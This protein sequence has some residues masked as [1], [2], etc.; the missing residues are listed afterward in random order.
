VYLVVGEVPVRVCS[1][2]EGHPRLFP[3]LRR[4]HKYW[5]LPLS[6][7]L[8]FYFVTSFPFCKKNKFHENIKLGELPQPDAPGYF[9]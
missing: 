3:N 2:E 1:P 9:C 7:Q 8:S 4:M 6:K 5:N